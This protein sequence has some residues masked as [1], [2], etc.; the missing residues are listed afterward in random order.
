MAIPASATCADIATSLYTESAKLFLQDTV[1]KDKLFGR[2]SNANPDLAKDWVSVTN[3]TNVDYT[4]PA[5]NSTS[6]TCELPTEVGFIM[7]SSYALSTGA[8]ERYLQGMSNTI[9]KTP[10]TIG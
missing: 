8:K 1:S 4:P 5:E 6:L 10:V 2:F 7:Y 9:Y 3:Y